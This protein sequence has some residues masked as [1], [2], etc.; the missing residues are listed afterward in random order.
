[1]CPFLNDGNQFWRKKPV[2][3]FEIFFAT[4]IV[5]FFVKNH[6]FL[7]LFETVT[8]KLIPFYNLLLLSFLSFLIFFDFA[9]I[10]LPRPLADLWG[11]K[12]VYFL[13]CLLTFDLILKVFALNSEN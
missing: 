12:T 9:V 2:K 1:M 10:K 5:I 13:F 8:V 3:E 7:C 6:G 11:F 4:K